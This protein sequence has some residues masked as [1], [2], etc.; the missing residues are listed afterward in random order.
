MQAYNDKEK[1]LMLTQFPTK[2]FHDVLEVGNN[3]FANHHLHYKEKPEMTESTYKTSVFRPLP[4]LISPP[5]TSSNYIVKIMKLLY[6]M[7]EISITR[8]VIYH[9]Y[10]KDKLRNPTRTLVCIA[11]YLYFICS[12]DNILTPPACTTKPGL[13]IKKR[14]PLRTSLYLLSHQPPSLLLSLTLLEIRLV[15]FKYLVML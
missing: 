11:N 4:Q 13:V 6:N 3:R 1:N 8:F 2:L 10:Y 9:P 15:I 14:E 7:P 12:L 5:V